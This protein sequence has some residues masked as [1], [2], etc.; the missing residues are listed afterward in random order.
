MHVRAT[1]VTCTNP[2]SFFFD[3]PFFIK[4]ICTCYGA[5][6]P[7]LWKWV[8][9]CIINNILTVASKSKGT[10]LTRSLRLVVSQKS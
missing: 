9:T 2:V 10:S 4:F 8:V 1:H 7:Y 6:M 3:F 5:I